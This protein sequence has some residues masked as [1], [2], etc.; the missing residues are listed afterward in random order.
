MVSLVGMLACAAWSCCS[1]PARP[2]SGSSG[3][4]CACSS[5]PRSPRR[6]PSSR[7]LA[8][9]GREGQLFGL[10]ATTGRAV[11]FLA[12]TLF[13]WRS[14]VLRRG[15]GRDRRDPP[16]ARGRA[17]GAVA[18]AAAGVTAAT[19]P[20]NASV[21]SRVN[22][23][24]ISH[25]G[26]TRHFR[27][28][29]RIHLGHTNEFWAAAMPSARSRAGTPG[30]RPR[31]ETTATP[32]LHLGCVRG[33][34]PRSRNGRKAMADRVLRGSRLG[35][36]SYETDRNHDLAPRQSMRYAC[37]RGHEFDVP[38]ANDAEIAC[39]LGVS[40]A[41]QHLPAGRRQRRPSRRRSSRR[42]PTGTCSWSG[43]RSPTWKCCWRAP[44]AAGRAA[45]RDRLTRTSR[46]GRTHAGPASLRCQLPQMA[47][48]CA[49][50]RCTI[51]AAGR[52]SST[53]PTDCAREGDV[54]L[55][56]ACEDRADDSGR[57]LARSG[58][59]LLGAAPPPLREGRGQHAADGRVV[60]AVVGREQAVEELVV[61]G[62][63]GRRRDQ[64]RASTPRR[65]ASPWRP[66]T[67]AH[68][69]A[70]RAERQRGGQP[71][72]SAIPPAATTG[73]VT[74]DVDD[75]RHERHRR[76]EAAV[77]TRLPALCDEHVG[78]AVEGLLAW[79]TS[80]TCWIQRMPTSCARS[81]SSPGSPM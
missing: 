34:S 81:T 10:Y 79:S 11:S 54:L 18:G 33:R 50:V 46:R 38:F 70:L 63:T 71:R 62:V 80:M 67:G 32:T 13:G 57:Q 2:C 5:G 66:G 76:D 16:G 53:S 12:P 9:P 48:A 61:L 55:P 3:C 64:H 30:P 26:V 45:R 65:C 52:T 28:C 41:R 29:E 51:S 6:G 4:S 44:R 22:S 39:H 60:R 14:R 42:A 47:A 25:K 68:G 27:M 7:R 31:E 21:N 72:P 1:S 19:P 20:G 8:P 23:G 37:P 75:L 24:D 69:H 58:R 35:A 56:A 17:R 49:H 77:P 73:V 74:G 15:P 59:E 36:V 78:A 40:P 43:A